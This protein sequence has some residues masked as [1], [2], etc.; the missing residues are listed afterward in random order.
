MLP[1]LRTN[2]RLVLPRVNRSRLL[3]VER[4][5]QSSM[6]AK[7]GTLVLL[8]LFFVLFFLASELYECEGWHSGIYM[9]MLKALL[10]LYIEMLTALF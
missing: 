8:F 1:T 5:L 10:R 2:R 9:E 3:Q 7:A 6:S 4:G